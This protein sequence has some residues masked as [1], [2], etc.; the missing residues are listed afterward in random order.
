MVIIPDRKSITLKN[1]LPRKTNIIP[2]TFNKIH[3]TIEFSFNHP[4]KALNEKTEH[5]TLDV[6]EILGLH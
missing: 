4:H 1:F 2:I 5:P 6:N 3:I